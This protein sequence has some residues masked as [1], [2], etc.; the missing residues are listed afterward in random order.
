[1][2]IIIWLDKYWWIILMA[3]GIIMVIRALSKPFK[4]TVSTTDE[5]T[6]TI[7]VTQIKIKFCPRCGIKLK[8]LK[9]QSCGH[10]LWRDLN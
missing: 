6:N 10:N 2:D 9:C 5:K 1:M 4:I 7:T 3:L 8:S